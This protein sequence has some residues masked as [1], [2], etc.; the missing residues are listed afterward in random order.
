MRK[1]LVWGVVC[2]AACAPRS[3]AAPAEEP[4]VASTGGGEGSVADF[5]DELRA[6][7][8]SWQRNP[9]IDYVY[10]V[11]QHTANRPLHELRMRV[12][13]KGGQIVS[14]TSLDYGGT[15]ALEHVPTL[16]A[17]FL[18]AEQAGSLAASEGGPVP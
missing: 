11:D 17:L 6:H 3:Q 16:D 12:V 2:G 9:L 14:A 13:V 7:Y 10:S 15:P 8:Q 18:R 5:L 4:G 1:I